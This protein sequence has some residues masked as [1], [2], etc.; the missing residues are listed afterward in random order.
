MTFNNNQVRKALYI[1]ICIL[2]LMYI[3]QP[4]HQLGA[5]VTNIKFK[6]KCQVQQPCI[7]PYLYS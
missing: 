3:S 2:A 7:T 4:H 6:Y 1:Q 5:Q